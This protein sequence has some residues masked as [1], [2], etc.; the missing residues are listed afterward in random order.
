MEGL[1]SESSVRV[2]FVCAHFLSVGRVHLKALKALQEWLRALSTSLCHEGRHVSS[3]SQVSELVRHLSTWPCP[4]RSLKQWEEEKPYARA[5]SCGRKKL[6]SP[7]PPLGRPAGPLASAGSVAW[8][9][10][11]MPGRRCMLMAWD[12]PVQVQ[13]DATHEIGDSRIKVQEHLCSHLFTWMFLRHKSWDKSDMP[14]VWVWATRPL[15]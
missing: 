10:G 13:R 9:V 3:K 8:A 15:E 2:L 5:T 6:P 1:S 7:L 14:F 11:L 4:S 12:R